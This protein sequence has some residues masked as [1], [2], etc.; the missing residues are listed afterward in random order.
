MT[1]N[2]RF[3]LLGCTFVVS[4][5]SGTYQGPGS[6]SACT[7]GPTALP[8]EVGVYP[9]ALPAA[10][11]GHDTRLDLTVNRKSVRV[12]V[13]THGRRRRVEGVPACEDGR[14][15]EV[16]THGQVRAPH[17]RHTPYGSDHDEDSLSVH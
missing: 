17:V 16:D 8:G 6:H 2:F 9:T 14:L 1:I 3:V 13:T 4:C 11:T 12:V 5:Q 15:K 7:T 10:G